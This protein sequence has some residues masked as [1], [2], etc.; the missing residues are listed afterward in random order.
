M[1]DQR[2]QSVPDKNNIKLGESKINKII[3]RLFGRNKILSLSFVLKDSKAN[4]KNP[5]HIIKEYLKITS[6]VRRAKTD[7][8]CEYIVVFVASNAH[9]I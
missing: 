9:D 7:W 4:G 1:F 6:T 8:N 5:M 3:R 2:P